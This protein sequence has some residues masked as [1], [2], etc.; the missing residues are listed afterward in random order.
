MTYSSFS[1]W[2]RAGLWLG[3]VC[4]ILASADGFGAGKGP[5]PNKQPA[6]ANPFFGEV[7]TATATTITVKGDRKDIGA[8]NDPNAT[9]GKLNIHFS[10]GKDVNITRDGQKIAAADIKKGEK[11]LVGFTMKDEF[12]KRRVTEIKVG[13][14]SAARED[15][16][17]KPKEGGKARGKD[18]GKGK[19]KAGDDDK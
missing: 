17:E 14:V 13:N 12:A 1:R 18:K 10:I 4:L 3:A 15:A 16:A 19:E 2:V 7:T 8:K 5:D 11:V 6:I 9:S